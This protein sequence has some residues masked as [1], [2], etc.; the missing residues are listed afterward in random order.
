MTDYFGGSRKERVAASESISNEWAFGTMLD[1]IGGLWDHGYQV[2]DAA[3]ERLIELAC[4][5]NIKPFSVSPKDLAFRF[6]SPGTYEDTYKTV[7]KMKDIGLPAKELCENFFQ[8][9][10]NDSRQKARESLEILEDSP[11]YETA[12]KALERG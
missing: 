5:P 8:Q 7:R 2:H 12:K 11:L 9:L 4:D 6:I 1:L 3:K 10:K